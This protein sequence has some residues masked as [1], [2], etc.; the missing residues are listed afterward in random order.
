MSEATAA[1][2]LRGLRANEPT[3]HPDG[4]ATPKSPADDAPNHWRAARV[5]AAL[6]ELI[7]ASRAS[8]DAPSG[9]ATVVAGGH[10]EKCSS[11]AASP[12][13]S[14]APPRPR[15]GERSTPVPSS[16]MIGGNWL[17]GADHHAAPRWCHD[18]GRSTTFAVIR[19]CSLTMAFALDLRKRTAADIREPP[20]AGLQCGG[21]GF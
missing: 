12:Q 14:A 5:G 1:A 11:S 16:A 18:G 17:R 2:H 19:S 6:E 10:D 8:A 7:G 3:G 13:A 9:V 20:T 15:F 4:R 21:Q